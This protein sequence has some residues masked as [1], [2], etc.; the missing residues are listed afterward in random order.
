MSHIVIHDDSNNV[1][2]YAEFD[3]L[4][5]AAAHL[6][7]LVNEDGDTTAR[8]YALEPVEFAVKSYVRIEIGGTETTSAAD[9]PVS[10]AVPEAIAEIDEETVVFTD[11]FDDDGLGDELIEDDVLGDDRIEY[12][13]ASL[14]PVDPVAP[15]DADGHRSDESPAGDSRRGLFGR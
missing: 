8:L 13:E 15:D 10:Q 11:E 7:D 3:D 6:E 1:T 5:A 4:Q 2:H 12:V 14:S 9:A